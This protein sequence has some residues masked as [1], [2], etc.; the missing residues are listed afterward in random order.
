MIRWLDGRRVHLVG[1]AP[2]IAAALDA[3]GAVLADDGDILIQVA[4]PRPARAAHELSH[5]A[6]RETV[7]AGLDQ[8]FSVARQCAEGCRAARRGGAA[9]FVGAPEQ[10]AGSDHAA[11][12]GALA[13]LTKNLG[14]G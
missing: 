4:V 2:A 7:D 12:A 11:A 14:C 8:R 10:S 5:D 1:D 13:N 3:H 9:L 6:W